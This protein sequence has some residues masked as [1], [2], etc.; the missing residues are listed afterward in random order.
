MG[1]TTSITTDSAGT[2]E[3]KFVGDFSLRP[4]AVELLSLHCLPD[5]KF[6]TGWVESVY[7]DDPLFSSYAEK[8]NGDAY[9]RKVR[10]RWYR[11][12]LEESHGEVSAFLEIKDRLCAARSKKHIAL[13][14]NLEELL[15]TPLSSDYWVELLKAASLASGYSFS[16]ALS[17]SLSVRYRRNRYICPVSGRRIALD[18]DISSPRANGKAMLFTEPVEC[19]RIVCEVKGQLQQEFSWSESLYRLGFRP[20]GFSKYG[21]LMNARLQGGM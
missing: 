16:E 13:K 4:L 8:R 1:S 14:A 19:S 21:I 18:A 10:I 17:P 15:F 6:P 2:V 12:S 9:K 5:P 3:R 20:S 11:N 7:F